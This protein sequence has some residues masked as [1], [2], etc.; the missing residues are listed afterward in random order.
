M[1]EMNINYNS[2]VIF[3]MLLLYSLLSPNYEY[4]TLF[5][6]KIMLFDHISLFLAINI[7]GIYLFLKNITFEIN[8]KVAYNVQ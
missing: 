1:P 4:I 7:I 8:I 5:V 2:T 3:W 6:N